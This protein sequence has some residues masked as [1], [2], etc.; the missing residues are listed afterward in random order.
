MDLPKPVLLTLSPAVEY[1]MLHTLL[2]LI[3]SVFLIASICQTKEIEYSIV[4]LACVSLVTSEVEHLFH[5]YSDFF[6]H[7][8]PFTAF[9]KQKSCHC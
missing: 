3:L 9:S 6:V 5:V 2:T 4:A 7:V 8:L 1:P